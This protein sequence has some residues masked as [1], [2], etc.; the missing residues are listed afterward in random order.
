[1]CYF[2]GYISSLVYVI[3]TIC[4]L[5]RLIV[6]MIHQHVI[7]TILV[8]A[9]IQ[10]YTGCVITYM[11]STSHFN[12]LTTTNFLGKILFLSIGFKKSRN[13]FCKNWDRSN[14]LLSVQILPKRLTNLLSLLWTTAYYSS[15]N[16]LITAMF[17]ERKIKWT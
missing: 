4:V 3:L 17:A 8:Q 15:A 14:S 5:Y 6:I 10:Q 7:T 1:M 11:H 2:S 13:P 9:W 16:C 12:V